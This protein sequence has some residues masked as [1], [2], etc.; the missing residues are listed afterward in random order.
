MEQIKLVLTDIDGTLLD[1]KKRI[2]K[3]NV[4]AIAKL[5]D[6]GILFGIA[7]GRTPFAVEKMLQEWGIDKYTDIIMGFNGGCYLDMKTHKANSCYLLSETSIPKVL[8][9]FKDFDF[10]AATF[11]Q[12]EFHAIKDD[13][14]AREICEHNRLELVVDDL[15]HYKGKATPKM[16]IMTKPEIADQMSEYAKSISHPN[17]RMVR[18]L[19]FLLEVLHPDLSKSRGIEILCNDYQIS[20]DEILTFGDELNDFEMIRDYTSVAMGNANEAIKKVANY[21]TKSN[22][23]DGVACFLEENIL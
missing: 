17:Y 2:S 11:D 20:K 6:K 14:Y 3:K 23:E 13:D 16:L 18:S 10:N 22:N 15:Y 7:T 8:D 12:R 5:K 19:P 21:I 1:D 4:Q 9:D